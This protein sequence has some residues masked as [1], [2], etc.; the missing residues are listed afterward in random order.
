[1]NAVEVLVT[2]A[3]LKNLPVMP[4]ST[5]SALDALTPLVTLRWLAVTLEVA[6]TVFAVQVLV[7]PP[8][9]PVRLE[10]AAT[11]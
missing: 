8:L 10:V 4:R 9:D 11:D 6:A 5:K 7:T 2:G 1:M 3:G